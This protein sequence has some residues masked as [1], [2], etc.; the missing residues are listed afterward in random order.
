ME[1]ILRGLYNGTR[2][3]EAIPESEAF[4]ETFRRIEAEE[5]YFMQKMSLDD[6]R[7]FQALAD[8]RTN[9]GR[10]GEEDIFSCGFALGLLLAQ[11]VNKEAERLLRR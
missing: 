7:R 6:C 5:A 2:L 1:S 3:S 10:A 4:R 8:L 9:L 11:E